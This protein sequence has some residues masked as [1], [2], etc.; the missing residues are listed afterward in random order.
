MLELPTFY[1]IKRSA[2]HDGPTIRTSVFFKGCPLRCFWCRNPE[3]IDGGVEIV[4]VQ[5]R[6]IGCRECVEGCPEKAL[7]WNGGAIERNLSACSLCLNCVE[8][9]PSLAHEAFGWQASVDAVIAEI[10]K[11]LILYDQSGGGVTFSGGEPLHQPAHLL[12]L[13]KRC[14]ALEIH[15]SV[16]TSGYAEKETVLAVARLTDL[17]LFDLKVMNPEKHKKYTGV[18]NRL[19]LQNLQV[20]D[21]IGAAVRVRFPLIATVNDSVENVEAMAGFIAGLDHIN[22]IDILVYDDPAGDRDREFSQI[23]QTERVY[24]YRFTPES[25]DRT[26]TILERFGLSVSVEHSPARSYNER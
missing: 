15:C 22:D 20:L 13:L 9:C 12:E 26:R 17:F 24:R 19:I 14:R 21:E 6:C 18:D 4:T 3:G 7:G 10:E 23:D 2:L 1:D 16:D 25:V 8:I 11:D 5:E